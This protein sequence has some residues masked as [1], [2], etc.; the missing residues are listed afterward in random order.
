MAAPVYAA[1]TFADV[2]A[3]AKQIEAADPTAVSM[4]AAANRA[5]AAAQGAGSG[6]SGSYIPLSTITSIAKPLSSGGGGGFW[7]DLGG[8]LKSIGS[9]ALKALA[10]PG[11]ATV[12]ALTNA[13]HGIAGDHQEIPWSDAVGSFTGRSPGADALKSFGV[14]NPTALKWG[15]MGIDMGVD[16]LLPLGLTK[17]G[18]AAEVV[19]E[20]SKA[21][22]GGEDV[23]KITRPEEEIATAGP[24]MTNVRETA[25]KAPLPLMHGRMPRNPDVTLARADH[26]P[27]ELLTPKLGHIERP[28]N[29]PLHGET[30][31][32]KVVKGYRPR[33]F[34]PEN[35]QIKLLGGHGTPHPTG[36]PLVD[37]GTEMLTPAHGHI[38]RPAGEPLLKESLPL[39]SKF[40][41]KAPEAAPAA[42]LPPLY[43]DTVDAAE[44]AAAPHPVNQALLD[45]YGVYT[46]AAVSQRMA[47]LR[48]A[49][50]GMKTEPGTLGVKYGFGKLSKTFD[51]GIN[52]PTKS[53]KVAA[54]A[55]TM[56]QALGGTFRSTPLAQIARRLTVVR[57]DVARGLPMSFDRTVKR[58]Q[59]TLGISGEDAR[60]LGVVAI[61][62][63]ANPEL[64]ASIK[65]YLQAQGHWTPAM[66]QALAHMDLT[67]ADMSA[68]RG[69]KAN[70]ESNYF[71]Q[72]RSAETTKA[73]VKHFGD[74]NVSLKA[75]KA[76][77]PGAGGDAL[78][79]RLFEHGFAGETG[80]AF[81][82]RMIDEAG[83]NPQEAA[84]MRQLIDEH[85][86]S[87]DMPSFAEEP[88]TY[89]HAGAPHIEYHPEYDAFELLRQSHVGHLNQVFDREI[90]RLLDETGLGGAT[91]NS[92]KEALTKRVETK[93][94]PGSLRGTAFAQRAQRATAQLKQLFTTDMPAHLMRKSLGEWFNSFVNG[95]WR[96][97]F[98]GPAMGGKYLKLAKGDEDALHAVY[99]LGNGVHRSGFELLAEA[100]FSGVGFNMG[101]VSQ[102]INAMRDVY[103]L[104]RN[105]VT[106]YRSYMR[107]LNTSFD[108][109]Q[110]LRAWVQYMQHG[111][112]MFTSAAKVLRT[113]FDY[114]ELT[115]FEKMW[116][117]NLMLFYSWTRKNTEL[118]IGGMLTRPGLYSASGHMEEDRPKLPNEPGYAAL[119]GLVPIPGIGNVGFNN[120]LGDAEKTLS[121]SNLRENTLGA[122]TPLITTPISLLTG[123]D[124][125]SGKQIQQYAGQAK[126]SI[127]AKILPFGTTMAAA[128]PHG[129]PEP[130]IDARVLEILNSFTPPI[131]QSADTV[132]GTGHPEINKGESI[133]GSLIGLKPQQNEPNLNATIANSQLKHKLGDIRT[134]LRYN[135]AP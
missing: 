28:P 66:D 14:T 8:A 112:D 33:G 114:G 61:S 87:R 94:I 59:E 113:R 1:P 7:S 34:R 90:E 118:H 64:G 111:D 106:K 65:A 51:T 134:R 16:P 32:I 95:G 80:T 10:V 38:T 26:G 56:K 89:D 29:T 135:Q 102:E 19:D 54:G 117:R 20:L 100:Q 125:G 55:N 44:S 133:I 46:P 128:H 79:A 40:G 60:R 127:W 27:K 2:Q 107:E 70:P 3:Q 98:Q 86:A 88:V 9:T 45:R 42:E 131:M 36:E 109:S 6:N 22:R 50:T 39:L 78:Q 5:L 13:A 53:L 104:A 92:V 41:T 120:P 49:F 119:E 122:A 15:G 11:N 124:V 132:T 43:G 91:R 18:K 17:I 101:Q 123:T 75:M 12:T 77:A 96:H 85:F 30:P 57:D 37:T 76:G 67:H 93:N 69:F 24:Q 72:G 58:M 84:D 103:A 74:T 108:N 110:R 82:Q 47:K 4:A 105:P 116:M 130:A 63:D 21:A 52:L 23:A 121:L 35:D 126:P 97:F 73:L 62:R 83:L 129:I 25:P 31:I 115:P 48:G 81:E 68:L 71:K 99:D